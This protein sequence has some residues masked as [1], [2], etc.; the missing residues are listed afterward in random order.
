VVGAFKN[1]Y[2]VVFDEPL[3]DGM[4][5][6]VL[7]TGDDD[8]AKRTLIDALAPLPFRFLDAGPLTNSR[9]VERMTLLERELA[10]RQG[11]HPRVSWR[12]WGGGV[13]A[14]LLAVAG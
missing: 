7:V 3:H 12:L 11:H 8:A 1:T 2:W 14:E 10:R 5:S 13:P 6:D 9:T 4:P